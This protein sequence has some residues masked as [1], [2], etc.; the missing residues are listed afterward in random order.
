MPRTYL[1][2]AAAALLQTDRPI[3]PRGD[4]EIAAE[5]ARNY[6]WN[7]TVNLLEG[8]VFWFGLSFISASTILPLFVSKLTSSTLLI[9]L[10]AVISQ[11]S[12]YLPQMFTANFTERMPRKKPIVVNLGIF[13]ERV[14]YW[15]MVV[16]AALAGS[17]PALALPLFF[18]GYAW[19]GLGAGMIAPAWQELLA[20]CFPVNRRGRFFGLTMFIGAGTAAAGAALSTWLL[21]AFPFPQSFV[22]IFAIAAAAIAVSWVFLAC[23]REPEQA[24]NVPHKSNRQ[25]LAQLPTIVRRDHNFRRFLVARSLLAVG[26]LGTGFITVSAIYRWQI[27]DSV[28]GIYTAVFMVGQTAGNLGFGLLAD[29]YGHKLSL[30]MGALASAFAF[31]L[32]LVAPAPGWI[33]AVF[34]LLGINTSALLVSGIMVNLEFSP[35]ERRPTYV[36]LANTAIG[37]ASIVAPLLGAWLA[38]RSYGWLFGVSTAVNVAALVALHWWVREPRFAETL[39]LSQLEDIP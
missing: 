19:R 13:L 6:R 26:G 29:R 1:R 30:E 5:M 24:V 9:G 15:L 12:W 4:D 2:R 31:I 21:E 11:G 38:T 35:P 34:A 18:A 8:A 23:T 37:I 20:R 22:L 25:F 28:V 3:A 36:G 33:F 27:A 16:S 32:A 7:F 17:S 14:P 10:I 39:Q